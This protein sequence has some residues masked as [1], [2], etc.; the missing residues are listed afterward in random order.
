MPVIGFLNNASPGPFTHLVAAFREGLKKVGYVEGQ[1]VTIEFRWA[2]GQDDRLPELAVD[3]VRRQVAVIATT[4][5][6]PPASAAKRATQTIPIVFLIG[7]DPVALRLVA[8]FNRPGA[9]A[10]GMTINA[11]G[12]AEKRW[13]LLHELVPGA[14]LIAI[15]ANPDGLISQL[16]LKVLQPLWSSLGQ[17]VK[18]LNA[19]DDHDIDTALATLGDAPASALF[20]LAEPLFTSRRDQIVTLAARCAVP[21][22][23]GFREFAAIGGLMSY[24]ASLADGYRQVGLYAG[25]I[26]KGAKPGDLPI[27]QPTAFELVINLKTAK[28]LRLTVPNT[29]LVNADEVIE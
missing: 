18:I 16:E 28:A 13:G 25:Q 4:G 12:T 10:T 22:C 5:G 26:L 1:N 2:E 15:L 3:L 7:E 11:H 27:L 14:A 29:L 19:R 21:A 17:Q 9:N 20:V 6:G 24:G 8:S 23:Y